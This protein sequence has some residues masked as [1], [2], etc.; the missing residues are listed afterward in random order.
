MIERRLKRIIP[1]RETLSITQFKH[2]ED[3]SCYNVWKVNY[4]D[5]CY[6]LKQAKEQEL[7]L[8]QTFFNSPSEYAPT[9]YATTNYDNSDYILIEYISGTNLTHCSRKNLI[10]TIDALIKMQDAYWLAND[11]LSSFQMSLNRRKNR[12]KYLK[13][14]YLETA[15][16]AFLQEFSDIPRT[17]CHDDLL[18]FNVIVS[19]PP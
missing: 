7:A 17:L 1:D 13:D 4:P 2:E 19:N 12:A 9:L 14:P 5:Q 10:C 6:V 18:P 11:H 3:E 15:Y 16:N 8:Y